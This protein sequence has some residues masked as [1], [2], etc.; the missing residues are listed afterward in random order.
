LHHDGASH[1]SRLTIGHGEIA[2]G[3]HRVGVVADRRPAPVR[4]NP[5]VQS[6]RSYD[7][8]HSLHSGASLMLAQGRPLHVVSEVLSHPT[9]TINITKGTYG[10][11]LIDDEEAAAKS[12][13]DALFGT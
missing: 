1:I 13:S 2:V 8:A 12:M 6:E 11:L 3:S 5:L 9:I 10:H 4:E 7:S